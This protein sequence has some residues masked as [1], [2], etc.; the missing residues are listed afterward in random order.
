MFFKLKK[1]HWV[2]VILVLAVG[3]LY[4]RSA[5][6]SLE[7]KTEIAKPQVLETTVTAT[8]TGTIK[9]DTEV[10]VTAQRAGRVAKIHVLEG[11]IVKKGDMIVSLD[12]TEAEINEQKARASLERASA[13]LEELRASFGALQ[14]E[15]QAAIDRTASRL[16]D[17]ERRYNKLTE[18][19]GKG[20]VSKFEFDAAKTEYEVAKAEHESALAGNSKIEAQKSQMEAQASAVREAREAFNLAKLEYDY[21]FLRSPI[22]GVV[23][24]VPVKL[25]ETVGKGSLVAEIIAMESLYVEAFIDE[26]DVRKVKLGQKAYVTMDAYPG[27]ELTG[28]VYMISPVVLG[29]R[30]ET[31]TFEVRTKVLDKDIELKPGMSAD[32][33]IIVGR[34]ENTLSVP[35]QAVIERGGKHYVYVKDGSR[36]RL[37]EVKIGLYNWTLTEIT[38]GLKESEEV[39]TT[40]DVKGLEDSARVKVR[41]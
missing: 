37:R 35:S 30:Q 7:V 11:D 1:I 19:F 12:S 2:V 3:F 24:S 41:N 8:A 6:K 16:A 39:I 36:A 5:G 29:E 26:A 14:A 23:T 27:R 10:K 21:S 33:E 18:L 25:G 20:F 32:I 15:V 22:D 31:R 34:V 4:I 17:A 28:K 9:S 38:S 13:V 40:P